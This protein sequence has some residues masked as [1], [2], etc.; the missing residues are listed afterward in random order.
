MSYWFFTFKYCSY[1]IS[2]MAKIILTTAQELELLAVS[3]TSTPFLYGAI[4]FN[5]SSRMWG[6]FQWEICTKLAFEFFF[7]AHYHFF[8]LFFFVFDVWTAF[9]L[10]LDNKTKGRKCRLFSSMFDVKKKLINYS[11]SFFWRTYLEKRTSTWQL[12]Q[13]IQQSYFGM[14][15]KKIKHS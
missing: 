13:S 6:I 3:E 2:L 14:K 9:L 5:W 1:F 4:Y 12:S 8:C 7:L 15:F 11:I 10:F